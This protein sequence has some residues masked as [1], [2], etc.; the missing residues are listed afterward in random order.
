VNIPDQLIERVHVTD[1]GIVAQTDPETETTVDVY[2]ITF[3]VVHDGVEYGVSLA[4]HPT[5]QGRQAVYD[6]LISSGTYAVLSKA[7][8]L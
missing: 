8:L 5:V 6:A 2:L 1:H 7:G 3:A 4:S